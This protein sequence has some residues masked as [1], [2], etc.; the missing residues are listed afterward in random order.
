MSTTMNE[1]DLGLAEQLSAMMDGELPEE[2]AR[3]LRKRLEHDAALRA[4]WSRLQLASACLKGQQVQPMA[5]DCEAI[6]GAD[7]SRS[8]SRPWLR[9]AGAASV[10][11]LALAL[12][13]R[14]LGGEA[15]TVA[16]PA[17]AIAP[18]PRLAPTPAA[19][20]L[21]ALR[22]AARALVADAPTTDTARATELVASQDPAGLASP[23]ALDATAVDGQSPSDFPLV[24]TGQKRWPRS[25]LLSTGAS[26]PALE[27]YLVR[28]NQMLANDGLAGFVPYVDVVASDPARAAADAT[29]ATER[30]GQ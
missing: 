21:V 12:A 26:D 22:P 30:G 3:F 14:F 13:P 20:D 4:S 27:A 7:P 8:A 25:G 24:D 9:W 28:H 6:R 16:A 2:Q 10:A 18:T 11:V 15:P 5:L 1:T 29:P 17:V 23:L 19:A